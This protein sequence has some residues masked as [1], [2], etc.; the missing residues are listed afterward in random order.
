MHFRN[1]NVGKEARFMM[2]YNSISSPPSRY[3]FEETWFSVA[4]VFI[5]LRRRVSA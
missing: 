4:L 2:L 1:P 3:F 5:E